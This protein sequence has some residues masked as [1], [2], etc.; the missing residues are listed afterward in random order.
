MMASPPRSADD[1][2]AADASP[3]RARS[4]S[5]AGSLLFGAASEREA[6]TL[7]D[8]PSGSCGLVA[9]TQAPLML[10]RLQISRQTVYMGLVVGRPAAA[11]GPA[12]RSRAEAAVRILNFAGAGSAGGACRNGF[13]I[14]SSPGE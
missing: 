4:P 11:L 13:R 2:A 5:G 14:V 8:S 9:S 1:S 6:A 3:T 10:Q 7:R 12:R